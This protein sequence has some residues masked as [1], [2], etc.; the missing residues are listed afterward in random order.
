[1][2]RLGN[3]TREAASEL[4]PPKRGAHVLLIQ[5]HHLLESELEEAT[6]WAHR[7]GWKAILGPADPGVGHGTS[8]GVEMLVQNPLGCHAPHGGHIIDRHRSI[9]AVVHI[10]GGGPI[11]V[12]STYLRTVEGPSGAN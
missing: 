6:G 11:L 2:S 10:P 9:G 1:M 8:S 7:H 5:E 4:G 12:C 3:P